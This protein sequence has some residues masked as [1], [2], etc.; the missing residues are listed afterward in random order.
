MIITTEDL[1][2]ARD[3]FQTISGT[4][5]HELFQAVCGDPSPAGRTPIDAAALAAYAADLRAAPQDP[6]G[7]LA[8]IARFA[9]S[10]LR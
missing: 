2:N 7:T 5:L 4:E 1:Y 10:F 8:G 9:E 6:I 3:E